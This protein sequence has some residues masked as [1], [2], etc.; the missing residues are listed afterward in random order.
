MIPQEKIEKNKQTK[1][2]PI[3][4]PTKTDI[5]LDTIRIVSISVEN[6]PLLAALELRKLRVGLG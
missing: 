1:T 5:K 4:V 3:P 2:Y 6:K